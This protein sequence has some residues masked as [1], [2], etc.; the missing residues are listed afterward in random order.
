MS[1]EA[2]A[3]GTSLTVVP[4]IDHVVDSVGHDPRS[5]YVERFWL[6][7]L[8]PTTVWLLRR[9]VSDLERHPEG[10]VVD[11]PTLGSELGLTDTVSRNGPFARSFTRAVQ[12]GLAQAYGPALAVRRRLPYVADR[13][14]TKF[15]ARLRAEHAE[16]LGREER[17]SQARRRQRACGLALTLLRLGEPADQVVW[18][19]TEWRF[20][21]HL[22]TEAT[23][24]AA[25]RVTTGDSPSG[26]TSAA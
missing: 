3:L 21:P 14:V 23:E 20:P 1:R 13:H 16:H 6:P 7:V 12:F 15:P 9:L 4:W 25:A 22:A 11:L 17:D 18:Q 2:V 19:L 5:N 8:G 10:V 24:W 26:A